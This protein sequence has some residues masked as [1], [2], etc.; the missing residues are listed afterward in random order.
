MKFILTLC[1]LFLST[2][3]FG[4]IKKSEEPAIFV[5]SVLVGT[6]S[7]EYIDPNDIESI[8]VIKKNATINDVHIMV[9]FT[10]LQKTPRN[11]IS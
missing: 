1:F 10:S 4:Q 8:N 6:H 7:M 11:I 3:F 9:K 5:D 2:L